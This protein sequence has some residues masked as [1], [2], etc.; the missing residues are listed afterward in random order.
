MGFRQTGYFQFRIRTVHICTCIQINVVGAVQLAVNFHPVISGHTV[1][2]LGYENTLQTTGVRFRR[3]V[4]LNLVTAAEDDIAAVF[5][6]AVLNQ[7]RALI[8]GDFISRLDS[9]VTVNPHVFADAAA[10][11]FHLV[12]KV[13]IGI[14]LIN[15]ALV[16]S[17]LSIPAD[18]HVSLGCDNFIRGYIRC[19]LDHTADVHMVA[20]VLAVIS[21]GNHLVFCQHKTLS[22]SQPGTLHQLRPGIHF[23]IVVGVSPGHAEYTAR[24]GFGRT[25][26]RNL[27]ERTDIRVVF[28]VPGSGQGCCVFRFGF[29]GYR[30]FRAHC[31][32]TAG[33]AVRQTLCRIA[34]CCRNFQVLEFY[35]PGTVSA[36]SRYLTFVISFRFGVAG[37]DGDGKAYRSIAQNRPAAGII[38]ADKGEAGIGSLYRLFL[39]CTLLVFNLFFLFCFIGFLSH[40]HA[41]C[42]FGDSLRFIGIYANHC[43]IDA[44]GF[45]MGHIRSFFA[46]NRPGQDVVA[47]QPVI[48]RHRYPS[49]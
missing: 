2:R 35:R 25:S 15:L 33:V 36:G 26:G 6:F 37:A 48:I 22:G 4:H 31:Y 29:H 46:D 13:H 28:Y 9:I 32:N 41:G 38:L 19:N 30:S 3:H 44:V 7:F 1:G 18:I 14:G 42:R 49:L 17:N 11:A 23:D 39:F 12:S 16:R 21:A 47:Q 45:G 10:F 5:V 24:T 40:G 20:P 8:D 27:L 34:P 43:Y